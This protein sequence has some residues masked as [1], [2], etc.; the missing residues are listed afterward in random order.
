MIRVRKTTRTTET[1]A[2][3]QWKLNKIENYFHNFI[4]NDSFQMKAIKRKF[5]LS[6]GKLM[7]LLIFGYHI[8]ESFQQSNCVL[9]S[10]G[11]A[12]IQKL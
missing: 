7:N 12:E 10:F 1:S 2:R 8:A 6:R 5:D 3:I 11:L 4:S 9:G